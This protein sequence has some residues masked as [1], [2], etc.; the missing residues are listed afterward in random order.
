MC[1]S[2]AANGSTTYARS[3][4]VYLS[5]RRVKRQRCTEAIPDSRQ[6]TA[7]PATLRLRR[8]REVPGI[9]TFGSKFFNFEFST[10]KTPCEIHAWPNKVDG[11]DFPSHELVPAVCAGAHI[12]RAFLREA[13]ARRIR[14]HNWTIW[15]VLS[16]TW[17]HNLVQIETY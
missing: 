1:A 14:Q 2:W 15:G 8:R 17:N 16:G 9:W 4:D 13:K 11:L 5:A 6:T 12:M 3:P 7:T 10:S